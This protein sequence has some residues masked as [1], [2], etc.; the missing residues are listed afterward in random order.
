MKQLSPTMKTRI[1]ALR[2]APEALAHV[3]Q[4]FS[5]TQITPSELRQKLEGALRVERI[6]Q[7]FA[8]LRALRGLTTREL[9]RRIGLSQPRVTALEKAHNAQVETLLR[10]SEEA[11][12]DVVLVPRSKD[13]PAFILAR[14]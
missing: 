5:E 10:L 2:G 9:G 8:E 6:G 13:D 11:D 4:P 1:A 12:Y 14:N 7:V 3:K